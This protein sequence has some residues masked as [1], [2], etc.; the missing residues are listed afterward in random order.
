MINFKDF[1]I[2]CKVVEMGNMFCVVELEVKIVM[3]IS[4]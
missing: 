2:F 4:K 3:V 1:V